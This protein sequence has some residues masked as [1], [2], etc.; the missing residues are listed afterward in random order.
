[1]GMTEKGKLK[2]E[3][4]LR[5]KKKRKAEGRR[6]KNGNLSQAFYFPTSAGLPKSVK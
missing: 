5:K 1:M 3:S 4:K 6:K 2:K